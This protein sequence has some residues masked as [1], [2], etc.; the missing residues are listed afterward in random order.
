MSMK[1][2]SDTFENETCDYPACNAVTQQMPQ[3]KQFLLRNR[4]VCG[5]RVTGNRKFGNEGFGLHPMALYSSSVKIRPMVQA[6][7]GHGTRRNVI[8]KPSFLMTDR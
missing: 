2:S 8:H 5:L 4:H 1:N 7:K 3:L 6:V